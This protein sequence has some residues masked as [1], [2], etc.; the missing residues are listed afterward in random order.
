MIMIFLSD[1]TGVM[2]HKTISVFIPTFSLLIP[3]YILHL[4][5]GISGEEPNAAWVLCFNSWIAI[6]TYNRQRGKGQEGTGLAGKVVCFG[7]GQCGLL[8][9]SFV[10]TWHWLAWPL[11][12]A[13]SPCGPCTLR[14]DG[15]WCLQSRRHTNTQCE[16]DTHTPLAIHIAIT[17]QWKRGN[18]TDRFVNRK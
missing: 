18:A 9:T 11:T 14:P 6:N 2:F 8:L 5:L 3:K 4:F 17:Q 10:R 15:K 16:W 7:H 12:F 1:P 13:F